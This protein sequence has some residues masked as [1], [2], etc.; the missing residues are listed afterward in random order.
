LSEL[1]DAVDVLADLLRARHL[2][3]R[4]VELFAQAG[5]RYLAD[6]RPG[7]AADLLG[8]AC[9]LFFPQLNASMWEKGPVRRHV[10]ALRKEGHTV[11]D[12]ETQQIYEL[13]R[14]EFT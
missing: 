7:R 3:A 5:H 11:V 8:R 12:P 13:W 4:A 2:L 9:R 1:P 14:R 10:A 6:G